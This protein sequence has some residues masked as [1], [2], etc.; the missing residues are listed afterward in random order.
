M[1]RASSTTPAADQGAASW[2]SARPQRHAR[3]ASPIQ[4]DNAHRP[5]AARPLIEFT[6]ERHRI[7][8]S[9]IVRRDDVLTLPNMPKISSVSSKRIQPNPCS[10]MKRDTRPRNRTW[11]DV[12]TAFVLPRASR[13]TD[14]DQPSERHASGRSAD[15]PSRHVPP[16]AGSCSQRHPAYARRGSWS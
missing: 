16:C 15:R 12:V 6:F 4:P 8:G 7:A 1:L 13:A 14:R 9:Q 2:R 10:F 3:H 5:V 11:D